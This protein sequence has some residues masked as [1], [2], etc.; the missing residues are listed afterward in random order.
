MKSKRLSL[1]AP[2]CVL[3]LAGTAGAQEPP[4]KTAGDR[5]D[6]AVQ[7]IKRG[8]KD[9]TESIQQQFERART[10]VHNMGV[11]GRV[12]GRLHWDKDLQG[13]KINLDVKEN[14]VATLTGTVPNAKAK[15]KAVSL[16]LDTVGVVNVVDQTT[17]QSAADTGATGTTTTTK[18]V[19]AEV[20]KP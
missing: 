8:A 11:A 3:A 10:S 5:L 12:Y 7:S 13:A 4:R 20:K 1:L 18:E 15:A 2:F 9:A 17:V 19:K 14:G 6:N 16:T